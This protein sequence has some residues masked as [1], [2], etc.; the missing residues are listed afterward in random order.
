MP[1]QDRIDKKAKEIDSYLQDAAS[2]AAF[3]TPLDL[4]EPYLQKKMR[5]AKKDGV[6]DIKGWLADE[7]YNDVNFL[8]DIAGDQIHDACMSLG[9][10]YSSKE[11]NLTFVRIACSLA[12]NSHTALKQACK[13]L[14]GERG[15][16]YK[17]IKDD[18]RS[19]VDVLDQEF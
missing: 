5:K 13:M 3:S 19:T 14:V 2:E 17:N 11:F 9:I 4:F 8:H 18:P 12:E 6:T 16:E 1:S 7:I 15:T 10:K